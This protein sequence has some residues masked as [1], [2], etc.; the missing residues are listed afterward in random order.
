M[1]GQDKIQQGY[2]QGKHPDVTM[3]P[4]QQQ[5]QERT[6]QRDEGHQRENDG[7][8]SVHAHGMETHRVPIQIM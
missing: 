6:R 8:P 3:T 1:Q 2:N 4:R 7:T 5:K